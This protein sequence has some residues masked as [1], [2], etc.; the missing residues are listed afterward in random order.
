MKNSRTHNI[1]VNQ[2]FG[3]AVSVGAQPRNSTCASGLIFI[4]LSNPAKP[5]SPGCAAQDGYVHDAQCLKYKGPDAKFLGHD[6]CYA[7]NEDSLTIYDVTDKTDTSIISR[8]SYEGAQYT[9]QGWLLDTENQEFLLMDD[10]YDEYRASG[11]AA[12]GFPVTYIWNISSLQ[13][14]T[15]TGH[16]KSG[17]KSIDH[18]QYVKN[19]I[20][21]QSNYGAGLRILDV[22]SIPSDPTGAGVKEIGFFDVYP[23]DDAEGGVINFV[24]SWASYGLFKSGWIVVNT[25]ERGVFVV[26]LQSGAKP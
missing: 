25:I 9:H 26:R 16:Y 19:G 3:Y 23:E 2:D 13:F 11:L 4:D 24:G 17:Q 1:V 21:Y 12:D 6:I 5:T 20:A 10:E 7:Y 18:N 8:T 15:Q 22:S 14:P